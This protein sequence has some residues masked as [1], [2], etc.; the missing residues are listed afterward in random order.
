MARADADTPG[1]GSE[2]RSRLCVTLVAD[3]LRDLEI[4]LIEIRSVRFLADH[5]WPTGKRLRPI[6]F[7]LSN[8]SVQVLRTTRP[9]FDGRESRLAA[10]I[11]LLHE[12]SL[13]HDDIVD[14][15]TVRR[16]KPSM[17]VLHG[18]GLAL[19]IGDYMVFRGLKLVLDAAISRDD[20]VLAQ[21]LANTGLA[22]AHGE[23]DQLDR[24]LNRRDG[25]SRM[26][27]DNYI[28]IIGK[29][30][31]AF[32]AGC[33]EAGAAMAGAGKELRQIYREFGMNM[34]LAFQ[35]V[36]DLMD[37]LGD[38]L[39]ASKTLQNNVAEGTVTLPMVHAWEL[40]PEDPLLGKLARA[41]TLN[42]RE[43]ARMQKI[44]ARPTVVEA[45]RST[46]DVYAANARRCLDRM[47]S[48]IYRVGLADLLDYIVRCPW[49]GLES[50]L[51][52]AA[53]PGDTGGIPPEKESN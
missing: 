10:A 25:A 16:G 49:G 28:G 23:A 36:D 8:L 32:F 33:A 50:T 7:L 2:F 38:P 39:K 47:P 22:I 3:L 17:Q 51:A 9:V 27:M 45:S 40:H 13:V 6:T 37:I 15:S 53:N 24:Y 34:G 18:E 29:K 42:R 52:R 20:I 31:A 19:L 46:M 21:E 26:S 5:P 1:F 4:H 44:L 30:T 48:S 11:E 41:E 43:R 12:A 14:R 35:M